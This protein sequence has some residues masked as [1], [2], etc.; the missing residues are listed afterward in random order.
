M[1]DPLT[2]TALGGLVATEGIKFLFSQASEVLRA[3]RER[4]AKKAAGELVSDR[5]DVPVQPSDALDA[6]PTTQTVDLEVLDQE[7]KSLRELVGKVAP[8]AQDLA[9]IEA[10]DAELADAAGRL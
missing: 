9:D 3:W 10:D 7:N 2:L 6:S 8:Y 1:P 5:L 4:R